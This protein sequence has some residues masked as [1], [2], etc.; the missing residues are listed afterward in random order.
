MISINHVTRSKTCKHQTLMVTLPGGDLFC[1]EITRGTKMKPGHLTLPSFVSQ[2]D[3]KLST[4][5]F[6]KRNQK[7]AVTNNQN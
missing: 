3:K 2:L 6:V 4:T 5:T 1:L 7:N